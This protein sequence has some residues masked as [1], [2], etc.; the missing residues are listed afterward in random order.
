MTVQ[1]VRLRGAFATEW[2]QI[3]GATMRFSQFVAVIFLPVFL[4]LHLGLVDRLAILAG[5]PEQPSPR[6]DKVTPD[7]LG[8]VIEA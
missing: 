1:L 3:A 8:L 7:S 6:E 4:L 5:A 2:A